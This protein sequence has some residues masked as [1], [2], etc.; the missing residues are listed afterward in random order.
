MKVSPA[1]T[2]SITFVGKPGTRVMS[3]PGSTATPPPGPSVITASPSPY[4]ST[5]VLATSTGSLAFCAP[6]ASALARN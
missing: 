4:C 3:P 5:H 2:V 6:L 1:P